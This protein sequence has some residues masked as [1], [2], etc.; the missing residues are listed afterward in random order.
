MHAQFKRIIN[1]ENLLGI[2]Q[3]SNSDLQQT[4]VLKTIKLEFLRQIFEES[5]TIKFHHN[6]SSGSP[7]V[8]RGQ[9][10]GRRHEANNRFSQFCGTRLKTTKLSFTFE[11]KKHPPVLCGI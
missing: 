9:T 3:N 6:P 10:D 11:W 4:R 2:Q 1:Y 8:P 5:S 7:A